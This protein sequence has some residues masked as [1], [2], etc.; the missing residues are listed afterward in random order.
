MTCK[1][2]ASYGSSPP[3]TIILIRGGD[4]FICVPY[5]WCISFVCVVCWMGVAVR[6]YCVSWL[7]MCGGTQ[8]YM[9]IYL[10]AHVGYDLFSRTDLGGQ[11][12]SCVRHN[13]FPYTHL[14]LGAQW[15]WLFRY[16]YGNES[17]HKPLRCR[18][19]SLPYTDFSSWWAWHLRKPI[20]D[21]CMQWVLSLVRMHWYDLIPYTGVGSVCGDASCHKSLLTRHDSVP[22]TDISIVYGNES[23]HKSGLTRRDSIPYTDVGN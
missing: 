18:H 12:H 16:V 10:C 22:Y 4:S 19:E 17:C 13:S 20:Q 6:S 9:R 5:L 8:S 23:C 21:V 1:D 2:K 11:S 14:H 7:V 3:S 15:G